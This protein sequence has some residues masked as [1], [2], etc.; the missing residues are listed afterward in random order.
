MK[1]K[2]KTLNDLHEEIA[3]T[4]NKQIDK[5]TIYEFKG[6]KC[7]TLP[8]ITFRLIA[9]ELFKAGYKFTLQYLKEAKHENL[10]GDLIE[11]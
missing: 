5:G 6:E 9:Q 11:E 7:I 4:I 8:I 3:E 2:P 10:R 1:K